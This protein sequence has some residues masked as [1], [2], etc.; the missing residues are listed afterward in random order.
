MRL[1]ERRLAQ[2]VVKTSTKASA[3]ERASAYGRGSASLS[4]GVDVMKEEREIER[5]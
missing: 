1:G 4:L 5:G 3:S 2:L